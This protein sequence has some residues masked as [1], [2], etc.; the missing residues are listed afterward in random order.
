MDGPQRVSIQALPPSEDV[1][2]HAT[3]GLSGRAFF[4][5]QRHGEGGI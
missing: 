5:L 2:S 1:H 3:C 4:L